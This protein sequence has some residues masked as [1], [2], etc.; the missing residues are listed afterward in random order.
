MS[1]SRSRAEGDVPEAVIRALFKP[2]IRRRM[3]AFDADEHDQMTHEIRARIKEDWQHA[4][5]PIRQQEWKRLRA[6]LSELAKEEEE[7][8]FR[9]PVG[10]T[11]R[12]RHGLLAKG[13]EAA[14]AVLDQWIEEEA[15]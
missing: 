5:P 7:R 6:V 10:S 13:I 3:P 8:A 11:S 12:T 1:Y 14:R 2:Y 15:S 9:H 4:V